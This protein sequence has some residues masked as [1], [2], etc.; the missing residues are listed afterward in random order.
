MELHELVMAALRNHFGEVDDLLEWISETQRVMG[1]V[2]SP[3]FFGKS[4]E[5]RQDRLWK[6]LETALTAEQLEKVG[7]I[8]TIAPVEMELGAEVAA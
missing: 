6:V 4:H 8:L 3:A 1:V 5:W 7:P 2:V